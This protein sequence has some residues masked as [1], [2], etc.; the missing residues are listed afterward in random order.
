MLKALLMGHIV[1]TSSS[2]V[3]FLIK[4]FNIHVFGLLTRSLPIVKKSF[5][6]SSEKIVR[7]IALQKKKKNQL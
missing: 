6:A 5:L 7:K 1:T 4:S 3:S 2:E